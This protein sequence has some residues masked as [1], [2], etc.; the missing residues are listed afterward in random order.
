MSLCL[1]SRF[2][3]QKTKIWIAFIKYFW[4]SCFFFFFFFFFLAGWPR[5]ICLDIEFLKEIWI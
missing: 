5:K 3:K 2:G 4:N 1:G